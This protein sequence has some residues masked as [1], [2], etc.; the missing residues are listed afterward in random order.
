MGLGW[1]RRFTRG[2]PLSWVD[3]KDVE[4]SPLIVDGRGLAGLGPEIAEAPHRDG[5]PV[6][7]SLDRAEGMFD[8]DLARRRAIRRIRRRRRHAYAAGKDDQ[9]KK[10]HI[11]LDTACPERCR[12]K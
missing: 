3:A 2:Q 5:A 11:L 4:N 8:G 10:R 7:P 6:Y 12:P 9:R 1:G